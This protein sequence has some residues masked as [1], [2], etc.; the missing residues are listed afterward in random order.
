MNKLIPILIPLFLLVSCASPGVQKESIKQQAAVYEIQAKTPVL[1]VKGVLIGGL[2]YHGPKQPFT[3]KDPNEELHKSYRHTLDKVLYGFG[4]FKFFNF[5]GRQPKVVD[6]KVV[7][8]EVVRPE[9]IQPE[10][11]QPEP[12]IIEQPI[13][14]P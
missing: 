5:L 11:I 9:V 13:I 6:P 12:I 7:R 14:T 4:L 8:P 2:E 10:V 1:D 3:F